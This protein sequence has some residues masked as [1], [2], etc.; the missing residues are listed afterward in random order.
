MPIETLQKEAQAAKATG[1]GA[2]ESSAGG[3]SAGSSAPE[4][5]A[6][7]SDGPAAGGQAGSGQH[8]TG[9]EGTLMRDENPPAESASPAP[10]S[11]RAGSPLSYYHHVPSGDETIRHDSL[12]GI[13][14]DWSKIAEPDALP[15][16]PFKIYMPRTTEDVVRAVQESGETG[17]P[18]V[19]R[20]HGRSSNNLVT[21]DHGVVLLTELMNRIVAVDEPAMTVTMQAG[22][23]L[24][25]VDRHL[26]QFGFGLSI[27]GDHD[28]VTAGGLASVGGI[29]PAS[30]RYGMF[31]DTVVGCEYVDWEGKVHRSGRGFGSGSAGSF[32]ESFGGSFAGGSADSGDTDDL[33]RLLAGTGRHGIITE[34]TVRMI[35]VDKLRTMYANRRHLTT[36][37][38]D[39]VRYS[40]A[41]I[42]DPGDAVME[43]GVWADFAVP[44][45]PATTGL[46][47]R[48]GQFSSYHTTGQQ[49]YKS[50][51]NDLAHGV[52]YLA[53]GLA[54]RLP[55]PVDDLAKYVGMACVML[56]PTYAG[57]KN[58][59][60]F[61]DQILDA[62]VREPTRMFAVLAPVDRYESLFYQLY[63]LCVAERR[64]TGAVTFISVY[65]RSVRSPYLAG[66]AGT[67]TT[68]N[69]TAMA[70]R[71][72]DAD[73]RYCELTL[74]I[75]VRPD[76]LTTVVLERLVGRIDQLVAAN[77]AFRHLHS[78]TSSD[79]AFREKVDPN[80]RYAGGEQD[81]AT[82]PG[83]R[84]SG[85][86]SSGGGSSA[87]SSAGTRR[88]GGS[89]PRRGTKSLSKAA[90]RSERVSR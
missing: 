69:T 60:R 73:D 56:N 84:S 7:T 68:A 65:V 28:H 90:E 9:Y 8:L 59:E 81:A 72:T 44:G 80:T 45:L 37:L 24:T 22:A 16:P 6:S 13:G 88:A 33:L 15:R 34:L 26:S 32:G 41:M 85:G 1:S 23:T 63:E 87:G 66:T 52:R 12:S 42:R 36:D 5:K 58:I 21:P 61:T 64:R 55:A 86:G 43:R 89:D 51:W 35:R 78:L 67:N 46:T 82:S 17:E 49:W 4:S 50:R 27:I 62:T 19:V 57:M 39:F 31:V 18:L 76:R 74:H 54:G 47:L 30:H 3:S 25:D 83:A 14:Y 10:G 71:D 75:G 70:D 77:G 53:G 38:N 40:N 20:G 2:S 29:S 79:P 48:L 11:P